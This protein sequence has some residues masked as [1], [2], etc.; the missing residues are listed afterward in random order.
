ME[1]ICIDSDDD[2]ENNSIKKELDDEVIVIDYDADDEQSTSTSQENITKPAWKEDIQKVHQVIISSS[3]NDDLEPP[4][5]KKMPVTLEKLFTYL[6][7]SFK[8]TSQ[9]KFI[10]NLTCISSTLLKS[11]PLQEVL[12]LAATSRVRSK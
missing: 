9:Q 4:P 12:F 5:P 7:A 3:D 8:A 1:V 2:V 6:T 11:R 10:H